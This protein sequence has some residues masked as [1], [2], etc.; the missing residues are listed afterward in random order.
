MSKK[1]WA[2][3]IFCIVAMYGCEDETGSTSTVSNNPGGCDPSLCT[4][5]E[6]LPSGECKP[7]HTPEPGP[8]PCEGSDC[9]TE[10]TYLNKGDICTP[11]DQTKI[12]TSP[13]I[14]HNNICSDQ[15]DETLGKSCESNDDC[16]DQDP[17]VTCMENGHCGYYAQ[18]GD[19]CRNI[20]GGT[21]ECADGAVCKGS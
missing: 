19:K 18:V 13:L 15:D 20:Q 7:V 10:I 11:G 14:C 6:C 12:C 1:H 16:A 4:S 2:T 5:G 9:P 17:F 21:I 8:Q 3:A